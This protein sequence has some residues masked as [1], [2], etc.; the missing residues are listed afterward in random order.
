MKATRDEL[1]RTLEGAATLLRG[2]TLNRCIPPDTRA[3]C[4]R[5]AAEIDA[6]TQREEDDE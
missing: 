2:I 4:A 3:V 1:V 5:R 6:L